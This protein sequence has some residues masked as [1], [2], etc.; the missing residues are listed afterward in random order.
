MKNKYTTN[1]C[2]NEKPPSHN[3]RKRRSQGGRQGPSAQ[4]AVAPQERPSASIGGRPL[5]CLAASTPRRGGV[6]LLM[7]EYR[8]WG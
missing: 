2:L 3:V 8:R 6:E 1:V 5:L 7:L 4:G